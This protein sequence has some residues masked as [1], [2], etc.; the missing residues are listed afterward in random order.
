M[1][2]QQF[3]FREKWIKSDL[4]LN[5]TFGSNTNKPNL[6]THIT[7][8][9]HN[10]IFSVSIIFAE[11][12]VNEK[13]FHFIRCLAFSSNYW[14]H[15]VGKRYRSSWDRNLYIQKICLLKVKT[16]QIIFD[17]FRGTP[18]YMSKQGPKTFFPSCKR[19]I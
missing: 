17:F 1:L 4:F 10:W 6:A 2:R 16:K 3:Q 18:F 8:Y 5:A 13:D 11:T 14:V 15:N 12:F 19:D 9:W 7:K